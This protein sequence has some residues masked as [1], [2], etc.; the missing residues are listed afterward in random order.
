MPAASTRP[1]QPVARQD[2]SPPSPR[3]P[4][5]R[6]RDA[7][8]APPRGLSPFTLPSG[9]H[10]DDKRRPS[11]QFIPPKKLGLPSATMKRA[12]SSTR[13]RKMSSPPPPPYVLFSF[14]CSGRSFVFE[15][16][17]IVTYAFVFSYCLCYILLVYDCYNYQVL[18]SCLG[19]SSRACRSTIL[20]RIWLPSLT[21]CL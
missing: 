20:T 5:A 12:A 21:Q 15:C 19:L 8:A 4:R 3:A 10:D 2:L 16:M 9:D 11:V 14:F 13:S 1:S 6:S 7:G 17:A 18:T